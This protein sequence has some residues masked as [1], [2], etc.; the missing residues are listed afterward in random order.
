VESI[1]EAELATALRV[2]D[3]EAFKEVYVRYKSEVLAL[4]ATMLGRQDEA[5]DLLHDVFV[6]LARQAPH[7]SSISNLK[8]YLLTSAANRVRDHL[9]KRRPRRADGEAIMDAASDA[10]NNP[11]YIAIQK[12]EANQLWQAVCTL[13]DEQRI[14]IA[15]R[16]YGGLNFKQI[17]QHQGI[18][19]NTAQ[20]RYRYALAKLRQK[21]AGAQS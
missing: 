17:A 8:G 4:I 19:E 9:K 11:L 21:Y 1:S 3:R 5:W 20:S 16:I 7:L 6:S 2:G 13:P 15:L 10:K 18:S 14:V 12:S